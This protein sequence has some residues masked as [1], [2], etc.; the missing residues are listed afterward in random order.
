V[1]GMCDPLKLAPSR[2]DIQPASRIGAGGSV[3]ELV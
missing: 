2:V 1:T 3:H